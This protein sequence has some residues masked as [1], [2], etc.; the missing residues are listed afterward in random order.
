[1]R[2]GV[3]N[4]LPRKRRTV[5][6]CTFVRRTKST[7]ALDVSLRVKEQQVDFG[8]RPRRAQIRLCV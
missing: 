8:S 5:I 2:R 6:E 4:T 1:M 7:Y 3:L